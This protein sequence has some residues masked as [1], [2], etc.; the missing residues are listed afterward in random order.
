MKIQYRFANGEVS[1]IEVDEELGALLLDLDRQEYNNDHKE[2]RRHISLNG[3]EYEGGVFASY[4]DFA[5]S[6]EWAEDLEKLQEACT[7]LSP[8]QREL[9][10]KVYFENQRIVDIA[11]A[12]GVTEAAIRNRLKKINARLKKFLT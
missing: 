4:G 6:V 3:M 11:R 2:T 7:K 8:G 12:E 10:R 9:V 1:E 5:E